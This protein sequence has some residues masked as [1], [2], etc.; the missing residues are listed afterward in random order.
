LFVGIHVSTPSHPVFEGDAILRIRF[1]LLLLAILLHQGAPSAHAALG[2][3]PRCMRLGSVQTSLIPDETNPL[4]LGLRRTMSLVGKEDRDYIIR[5]IVFE[6]SG[7]VEV[8][9][10][11]VAH[12][13]LNRLRTGRWGDTVKDVVTHPWQFEPWMTKKRQIQNLSPADPRYRDAARIAD[14]VLSGASP[15]PTAGATH[16]L[17]PTIV[18]ERRGGTLPGWAQGVGQPIGNHTF[19]K[20]EEADPELQSAFSPILVAN[21]AQLLTPKRSGTSMLLEK[22]KM[23]ASADA[24]DGCEGSTETARLPGPLAFDFSP[25]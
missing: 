15:D 17:N 3:A 11:A 8:G 9:K 4:V 12:V 23:L 14:E 22:Q 24:L 10:A 2:D 18:R 5:T 16:F 6:A 25:L 20:P 19:F 7:E 13:I 21:A 1:L